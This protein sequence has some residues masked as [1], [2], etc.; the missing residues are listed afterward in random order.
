MTRVGLYLDLRIPPGAQG[1]DVYRRTRT[2]FGFTFPSGR[3]LL[4]VPLPHLVRLDYVWVRGLEPVT[5]SR[6][7]RTGSDHCLVVADVRLP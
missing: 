7:C 4:G 2:G 5:A 3:A 6:D 1:A